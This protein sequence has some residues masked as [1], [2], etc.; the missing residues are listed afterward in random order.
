MID[1]G[2]SLEILTLLQDNPDMIDTD[3]VET[4]NMNNCD[5]I[6]LT[7]KLRKTFL[8][9]YDVIER[10]VIKIRRLVKTLRN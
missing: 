3:L 7:Q 6:E 9:V 8:V 10:L 2:L 4:S 5:Q 1:G